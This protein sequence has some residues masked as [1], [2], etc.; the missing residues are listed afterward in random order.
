[1]TTF[2]SISVLAFCSI[3]AACSGSEFKTGSTPTA[4]GPAAPETVTQETIDSTA[5]QAPGTTPYEGEAPP[6]TTP[7]AEEDKGALN[8]C[9]KQWGNSPFTPQEIAQPKVVDITADVNNNGVIYTDDK[10]T[11]KPTLFLVNFNINVGNNGQLSFLN[12]KGWYCFNV[13]AKV[14]NNFIINAACDTHVAIVSKQAQNDKNFTI[15]RQEPCP[16][17]P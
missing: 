4:D 15:A 6:V 14:I 3:L 7:V 12:P 11:A 1:V 2:S 9:I 10:V 16:A 13:K 5:D 17:A 8:E